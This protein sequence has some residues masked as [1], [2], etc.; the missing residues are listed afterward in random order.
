[1]AKIVDE[2]EIDEEL[3]E[4]LIHIFK[5]LDP[6]KANREGA[7]KWL[8]DAHIYS[9]FAANQILEDLEA[10]ALKKHSKAK[11]KIKKP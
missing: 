7:L 5:I 1:M 9:H 6:E 2:F 8:E 3:I 4:R 11:K 10:E